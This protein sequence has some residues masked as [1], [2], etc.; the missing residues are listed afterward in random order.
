MMPFATMNQMSL[1]MDRQNEGLGVPWGQAMFNLPRYQMPGST[2]N[3]NGQIPMQQPGVNF[4]ITRTASS[5]P[6][7]NIMEDFQNPLGGMTVNMG[8]QQA[9]PQPQQNPLRDMMVGSPAGGS[10]PPYDQSAMSGVGF[11]GYSAL[12]NIGFP[13]QRSPFALKSRM[14][15]GAIFA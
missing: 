1:G 8:P 7:R 15:G 2:M 11:P 9:Q 6:V 10:Y 4:T 12:S 3:F 13:N 5:D 14:M